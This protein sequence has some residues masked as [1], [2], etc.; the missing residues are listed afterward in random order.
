MEAI[1]SV[2]AA[3]VLFTG[4]AAFGQQVSQ[5]TQ[6]ANAN[7][8]PVRRAR[9]GTRAMPVG[10]GRG[11]MNGRERGM[12]GNCPNGAPQAPSK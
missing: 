6:G 12:G 1:L 11:P 7:A 9:T 2:L 10:E 4:L 5:P 8:G 3:G